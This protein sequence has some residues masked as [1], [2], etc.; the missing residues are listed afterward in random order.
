MWETPPYH[1][2][3]EMQLSTRKVLPGS[4]GSPEPSPDTVGS[5]PLIP[6]CSVL[7][8]FGERTQAT[9]R[10]YKAQVLLVG[11]W[12]GGAAPSREEAGLAA[13]PLVLS[14]SLECRV[15]ICMHFQVSR[16]SWNNSDA[17]QH[18]T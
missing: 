8:V 15:Q 2:N 4:L 10:M 1:S 17:Y 16:G 6:G 3:L 14:A 9:G 11:K 13:K 12:E 5:S 18:L 7:C